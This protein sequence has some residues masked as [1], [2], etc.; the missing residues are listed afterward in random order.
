MLWLKHL[1]QNLQQRNRWL[2]KYP[3]A[4]KK[5]HVLL[6]TLLC[7]SL[8][9]SFL[10][11]F[12]TGGLTEGGAMVAAIREI[13]QPVM[14]SALL[15]VALSIDHERDAR[16]LLL[17]SAVLITSVASLGLLIMYIGLY[18]TESP[19]LY[20]VR[21]WCNTVYYTLTLLGV[22]LYRLVFWGD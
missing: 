1:H 12:D 16:L 9:E 3:L 19:H 8:S 6:A 22:A 18:L 13:L 20:D 2:Q 15:A 10:A 5:A 4:R 17:R 7:P 21:Y 14:V 11:A